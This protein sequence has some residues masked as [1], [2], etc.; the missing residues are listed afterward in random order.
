MA[1]AAV[2]AWTSLGGAGQ[3]SV[4][5]EA[6][7]CMAKF[8]SRQDTRDVGGWSWSAS[9]CGK[10]G[11]SCPEASISIVREFVRDLPGKTL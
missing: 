11:H 8:P 1:Y 7:V 9:A 5:D 2:C 3:G 4:R 6:G 10:G